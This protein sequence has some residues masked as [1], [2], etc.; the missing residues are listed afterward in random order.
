MAGSINK[1]II[2]GNLGKDPEVR[3]FPNGGKV[4]NFPVATSENWQDKSSG[5]RQERTQWLNVS[6]LS[7]PI[8]NIAENYLNKGS[9][10]YIE[11]Q[12]ATRKWQDNEGNDRQS[13][14]VV[15]RPYKGQLVLVDS[16]SE[17]SNPNNNQKM[18]DD[19]NLKSNNE[20]SEI[21]PIIEDDE[22]PFQNL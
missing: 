13:T 3:T 1:V 11:G 7:E 4:C 15:L 10:V 21:P 17:I 6:I 18:N 19:L 12:I 8:V 16:R 20:N 2:L 22:I 9:K 14:E 5:E